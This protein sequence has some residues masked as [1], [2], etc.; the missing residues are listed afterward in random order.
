VAAAPK[1]APRTRRKPAE[2][3]AGPS[4]PGAKGLDAAIYA[5]PAPEP[6]QEPAKK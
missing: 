4:L 6:E 3:A 2:P 1:R 5:N